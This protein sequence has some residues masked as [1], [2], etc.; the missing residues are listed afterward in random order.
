MGQ[1]GLGRLLYLCV[2]Q[3][4][5]HQAMSQHGHAT[6]GAGHHLQ[7]TTN[8]ASGQTL[9]WGVENPRQMAYCRVKSLGYEVRR[10]DVPVTC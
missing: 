2:L 9:S 7:H 5:L 1:G 6:G 10:G 4:L 8:G 3:W